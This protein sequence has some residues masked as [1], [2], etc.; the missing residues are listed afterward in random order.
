MAYGTAALCIVALLLW[1]VRLPVNRLVSRWNAHGYT[2]YLWQNVAYWI[3]VPLMTFV[4]PAMG[5]ET[6]SLRK[7]LLAGV[8][9]FV[10]ST[11]MS[12]VTVPVERWITN[13]V[14]SPFKH[15]KKR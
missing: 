5:D 2:I 1:S 11:L 6:P 9:I 10:I 3:A 8:V 15:M 13:A 4:W 7:L 14:L 12:F